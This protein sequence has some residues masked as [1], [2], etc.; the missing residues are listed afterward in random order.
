MNFISN[1]LSFERPLGEVLTRFLFYVFILLAI[2]W[3]LER[4]WHWI[5]Y[6]DNDWDRAL[7]GLIKT[8]FIVI[9]KLLVLR[10]IAELVLAVLRLDKTKA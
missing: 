2:L 7:W 3:G 9:I 1:Y 8:P 10:V 4:M 5:L 6:L